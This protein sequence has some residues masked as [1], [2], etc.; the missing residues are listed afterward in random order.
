MSI[1]LNWCVIHTHTGYEA[2]GCFSYTLVLSAALYCICVW[3]R[4][5][6]IF[7]LPDGV[8]AYF[9]NNDLPNYYFITYWLIYH[10]SLVV[11]SSDL[12]I[13]IVIL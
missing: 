6:C 12:D 10:Y 3:E 8:H 5:I 13:H 11:N 2:L 7:E 4:Y 1:W 9:I